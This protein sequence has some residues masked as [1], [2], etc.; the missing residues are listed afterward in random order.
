MTAILSPNLATF[1]RCSEILRPGAWVWISLKA[2]PL[3][4]PGLRSHRSM[5]LGPPFIHNRMHDRL[6]LRMGAAASASCPNQPETEEPRTP[7]ADSLSQS[8]RDRRGVLDI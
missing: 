1:G 3:A 4:W 8:R 6:R 2:P 7:R 5:V